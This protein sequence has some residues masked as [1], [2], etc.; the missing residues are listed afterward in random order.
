MSATFTADEVLNALYSGLLRGPPDDKTHRSH[1]RRL[2]ADPASLPELVEHMAKR[3]EAP[4]VGFSTADAVR[5]LYRSSLGRLPDPEGLATYTRLVNQNSAANGLDMA[6]EGL[7]NSAE[8]QDRILPHNPNR[9]LVDHTPNGEFRAL[10]RQLLARA[11]GSRTIVEVGVARASACFSFDIVSLMGWRAVLVEG[12]PI[13]QAGIE[14]RFS[15]TNFELIKAGILRPEP[16]EASNSK[17]DTK[18]GALLASA[19]VPRGFEALALGKAENTADVL[20]ELVSSDTFTP[21]LVVLAI[22]LPPDCLSLR[23]IGL[24]QEVSR[25]YEVVWSTEHSTM[26]ARRSSDA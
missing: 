14:A 26:L 1:A 17:A 8:H 18:L 11:S 3:A 16:I 6:A 19:G 2:E 23:Q 22:P 21:A 24:S 10:L 4:T 15:G 9:I 20:N 25:R 7:Y 5:A 13:A 12:S